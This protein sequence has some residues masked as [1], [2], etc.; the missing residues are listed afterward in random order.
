MKIRILIAV[1]SAV[2]FSSCGNHSGDKNT[3]TFW[4]IGA[5]GEKVS[6]LIP[7]F[8]KQNPGVKVRVQQIPWTAAHEKLITAFAS[9]TLPDVFQ[10]GNTWV[11]EFEALGTIEVLND[12]L[13]RSDVIRDTSF[14]EGILNTNEIDGNIYGI[15]WY[16]DTRV[17]FYRTDVIEKA[18]YNGPPRTWD[19]LYD[20][21]KK[22]KALNPRDYAFFLPTNE[23]L[24]FILFGIQ[25][26]SDLLKD[27]NSYGNFSGKEFTEAFR[28]LARYYYEGLAPKDMQAVLNI[29]QAFTE[30]YFSM[31]ITGPWNV[32]EM[33]NRLPSEMQNKWMTAPLPSP[34]SVY[35]GYS[36]AGGSSIVINKNSE[37]KE[38]AW[39]FTEFLSSHEI[40]YRFY[41][42]VSALPSVKSVWD[43][44]ALKND[45]YMQ[46]FYVQLNMTK[47]TPKIPEWE[48]IVFAKIQQYAEFVAAG[49]LTVEEA[50]RELDSD[51]DK[52]LEKRRWILQKE[53]KR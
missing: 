8:E 37:K 47:A 24:P 4:A 38:L 2:I 13:K 46:A 16:V 34:D 39:R 32:T 5:E 14:F 53:G 26:G 23:W 15:P 42:Q 21:S 50:C 18:G 12:Y 3:I 28:Y 11:P 43:E 52:I 29:Y 27:N 25:N 45:K 35:P 10:V 40:Q 33:K 48:Q 51:T 1:I 9:G 44:P 6:K 31:V 30:E 7:E 49:K 36:L 41:N 22:I 17:L 20:L 19:E